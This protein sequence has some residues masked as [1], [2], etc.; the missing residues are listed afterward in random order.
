MNPKIL[1]VDDDPEVLTVYEETLGDHG[2]SVERATTRKRALAALDEQG[3]WD[4]VILDE[5][6]SGPGGPATATELLAE[7]GARAPEARTIVITGFATPQLVRSAIAAGAWDYLQKD[8]TF[9]KILLPLRV[10]HAVEAARE[11]RLRRAG[12]GE[13]ESELVRSWAAA[14]EHGIPAARKGRLLE[15]T[16][17]LLLRTIPGLEEVNTQRRGAAEEF[18]V[19]V[20]NEST[21]PVLGKEGSFLLV[22]CKNWSTPADAN[23]L[24]LF[25]EKLRDRF[26][27]VR[28]GILVCV[29]GFTA[30]V[31]TRGARAV[32]DA[33]LVLCLDADALSEW[34]DAADRL[35][36]LKRRLQAAVLRSRG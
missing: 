9:L 16:L 19:I 18:D 25:R 14:R 3:P 33:P 7:I 21:D 22:E 32:Q 29:G 27:R 2:F 6:L 26:G 31:D 4:V 5:K 30:G 36:W 15:D 10:R 12:R 1:L 11:R 17:A 34:I 24:T 23:V 28:L 35:A 20:T 8:P 13:V